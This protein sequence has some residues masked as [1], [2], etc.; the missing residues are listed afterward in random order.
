MWKIFQSYVLMCVCLL[1]VFT[2]SSGVNFRQISH[3][4]TL[5]IFLA[6][7]YK[8]P[9]TFSRGYLL[10]VNEK[11]LINSIKSSH[12]STTHVLIFSALSSLELLSAIIY[13]R[14]FFLNLLLLRNV[15]YMVDR[16]NSIKKKNWKQKRR[17]FSICAILFTQPRRIHCT[18]VSSLLTGIEVI[19]VYIHCTHIYIYIYV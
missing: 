9:C 14:T 10:T 6:F 4:Y 1:N 19:R 16:W 18:R 2:L 5:S 15:Y 12:V 17:D 3:H 7:F 11:T 8:S 13:L